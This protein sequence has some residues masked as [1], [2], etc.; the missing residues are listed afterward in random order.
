MGRPNRDKIRVN[1]TI[2]KELNSILNNRK[3]NKSAL[4]NSLLYKYL[5]LEQNKTLNSTP[6]TL[7]TRK[8]PFPDLNWGPL[9]YESSTLTN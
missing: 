5:T 8:C 7:F 1:F 9:D 3:I 6:K 4:I 2:D